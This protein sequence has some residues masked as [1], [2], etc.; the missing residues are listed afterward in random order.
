MQPHSVAVLTMA[1]Y[2]FNGGFYPEVH[3]ISGA[4]SM[5]TFT[6]NGLYRNLYY[7]FSSFTAMVDTYGN[8][9]G[10]SCLVR[11][12]GDPLS[13]YMTVKTSP[14]P[15]YEGKKFTIEHTPTHRSGFYEFFALYR[16]TAHGDH[17]NSLLYGPFEASIGD[18]KRLS[19]YDKKNNVRY[20]SKLLSV[21][22]EKRPEIRKK[23]EKRDAPIIE[24]KR[25]IETK[26]ADEQIHST[27]IEE[28]NDS[29]FDGTRIDSQDEH[30]DS[31][32]LITPQVL[33]FFILLAIA[34]ILV[35]AQEVLVTFL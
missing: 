34:L 20:A 19:V 32:S 23:I 21:S 13:C 8:W 6:K 15:F 9:Y 28:N 26:V 24:K 18:S 4:E 5:I 17:H 11:R 30:T 35:L 10:F 33:I 3:K 7:S 25:S 1:N 29:Q 12:S 22:L 31:T 16:N 27:D 2:I 14:G